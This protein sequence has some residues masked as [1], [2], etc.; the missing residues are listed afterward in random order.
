MS[1]R[2]SIAWSGLTSLFWAGVWVLL[3]GQLTVGAI[4]FA[5]LLGVATSALAHTYRTV[6]CP[7]IHATNS[8]SESLPSARL[9]NVEYFAA[10]DAAR[11]W[12]FKMRRVRQTT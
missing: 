2:R 4:A 10:L 11:S 8:S 1:H 7:R 6:R 5:L 12:P 9:K 3:D